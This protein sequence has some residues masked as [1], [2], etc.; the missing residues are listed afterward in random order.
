M[1]KERYSPLAEVLSPG[2]I[3]DLMGGRELD[4]KTGKGVSS[5]KSKYYLSEDIVM[6]RGLIL[7]EAINK[8][9]CYLNINKCKLKKNKHQTYWKGNVKVKYSGPV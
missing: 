5:D 4:E 7:F 6:K 8:R 3:V 9:K 1:P 2:A